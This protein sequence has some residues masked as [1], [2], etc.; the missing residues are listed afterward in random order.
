[1]VA[2]YEDTV[3]GGHY[4]IPKDQGVSISIPALHRDPAVWDDPETF[5]IDRFLPEN[6]ARLH[7]H[8]YKPFGSGERACI[9]RQ[10]ALT[11][12]KLALAL[13]LQRFALS[14][15]HDYRLDIR[16][17]LT[18]K[19]D[20]LYIRAR[21][22]QPHERLFGAESSNMREEAPDADLTAVNGAGE[23]FIAAYGSS[24][25]TA[26]DIAEQMVARAA[27]AG[28]NAR[29]MPLDTLV[30]DL[31][32]TGILAV[33]T[34]TYNGHAP[35]SAITFEKRIGAGAFDPV[36]RPHL[37]YAVLGC[38][39]TQWRTYQVFPKQVEQALAATAARPITARGEADGNGDFEGMA[40][41]WLDGFWQALGETNARKDMAATVSVRFLDEQAT[42]TQILPEGAC[43]L[44]VIRNEALVR[45]PAGLWDFSREAP[46]QSARH[47]ILEL[48]EGVEY[49][50]GDHLAVYP[51][52]P[53]QQVTRAATALGLSI[54][55][56]L[57]LSRPTDSKSLPVD[58][59]LSVG[60]VLANFLELQDPASRRNVRVLADHSPCPH[61]RVQLEALVGE[62]EASRHRFQSE[63]TAKRLSLIDLL[64]RFPAIRLPFAVFIGL[65]PPLRPRF[66]SISSSP[67][68][69][70]RQLSLTVGTV[71][72]PAW[73]GAG[74]YRG[75]ASNFLYG[76]EAGSSLLGFIRT[77]SPAF[78]PPADPRIPMILIGPGTGIAPFRGFL[79]ERGQQA[80]TGERVARSLL[81]SGCRHPRHDAFYAEELQAWQDQGLVTLRQAFS[82]VE[83]HPYRYVQDALWADR[84]EIR[85]GLEAGATIY[86]CGDGA[87][88][89]PAVRG[90]LI[91]IHR[92]QYGSSEDQA[93]AWLEELMHRGRYRQDVFGPG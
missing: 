53:P 6:E 5:D 75:V 26:R 93:C 64:E 20:N 61:T 2:P 80:A 43:A 85:T 15:P 76:L 86:V 10:F 55:D 12:A 9:G 56:T 68:T 81:F 32:E 13:V 8:A 29:C 33:V 11:E 88:M 34:A 82:C 73:S 37:R 51:S 3:I 19:P 58:R 77:P 65:C 78:A 50:T 16:E 72:G 30:D 67:L 84:R 79:Q 39:N 87:R 70:P 63:I 60:Q 90:C 7:P 18:L 57:V 1:M 42:R 41:A 46:L 54:A 69:S 92:D 24:L 17:T 35:D 4:R 49:L 44:R 47:L 25:G 31:P 14:D 38:G 23:A 66:Y 22:R 74:I 91:R 40:E 52:N 27:S 62:D 21:R 45:D 83:D 48:P 36:R 28:F 71:T 89:A 59:V